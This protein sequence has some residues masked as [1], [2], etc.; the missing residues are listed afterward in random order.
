MTAMLLMTR[1]FRVAGAA[2]P[3][4][5]L[6]DRE[7]IG[8]VRISSKAEVPIAPGEHTP[9]VT[10]KEWRDGCTAERGGAC[11]LNASR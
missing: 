7:E 11:P 9:P 10:G 2:Q 8:V 6:L 4:Q 5:V 3:Y 1:P